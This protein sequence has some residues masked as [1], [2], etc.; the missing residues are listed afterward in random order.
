ML[1][2]R[3][4][5]KKCVLVE[6]CIEILTKFFWKRRI[7]KHT[8]IFETQGDVEPVSCYYSASHTDNLSTDEHDSLREPHT[9]DPAQKQ[10]PNAASDLAE[11][12][13]TSNAVWQKYWTANGEQL[14]WKS[15]V[16]KY[17]DYINPEY[18]AL[19]TTEPQQEEEIAAPAHNIQFSFDSASSKQDSFESC[20]Q[21]DDKLVATLLP[22]T[23][24][25]ERRCSSRTGSTARTVDSMTNVTRMTVSSGD[26]SDS[27]NSESF[28]SVSSVQSSFTSTSSE[29][30]EDPQDY[31]QQWNVL[32]KDHYEEQYLQHY[33]DFVCNGIIAEE[34]PEDDK[35]LYLTH[36]LKSYSC[37][38]L[39]NCLNYRIVE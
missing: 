13:N 37:R 18:L 1:S 12:F 30:A 17:S 32:W 3:K 8:R 4:A 35:G 36:F 2:S 27:K 14:I 23:G 9:T 21:A 34:T 16:S 25:E 5:R 28:S 29:E 22:P 33:K 20:P 19:K 39:T 6:N 31:D 7:D 10:H 11:H 26:L 24:D 38:S 15:W